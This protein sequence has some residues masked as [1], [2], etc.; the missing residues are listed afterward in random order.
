MEKQTPTSLQDALAFIAAYVETA[1][2][3]VRMALSAAFG[4]VL[5]EDIV[6]PV[7][8]ASTMPRWTA[9]PFAPATSSRTERQA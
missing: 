5:A 2:P 6:A 9:L 7:P 1:L 8:L 4:H 3:P